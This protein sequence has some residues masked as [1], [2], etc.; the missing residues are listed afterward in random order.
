MAPAPSRR[1]RF[2]AMVPLIL[3]EGSALRTT[4]ETGEVATYREAIEI[5]LAGGSS[6]GRDY[7]DLPRIGASSDGQASI[8][9]A[10]AE[11]AAW[12]DDLHEAWEIAADALELAIDKVERQGLAFPFEIKLGLRGLAMQADFAAALMKA[13]GLT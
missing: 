6:D 10:A 4:E 13:G 3:L 7:P 11:L 5:V 12:L 1:T 2:A 9:A 8:V